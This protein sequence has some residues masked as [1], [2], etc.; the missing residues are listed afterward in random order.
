MKLV[1]RKLLTIVAE[2]SLEQRL[3]KLLTEKGCQGFT[4]LTGHGSGPK[5][6]RASDLEGGNVI[7][8]AV[9]RDDL[10]SHILDALE[11]DYFQN[12]ACTV[13]ISNVEVVRGERY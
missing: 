1:Q 6:L 13:W 12:Y 11:V 4:V 2:A 7:I 9:I 8:E 3:T 5:N 10:V